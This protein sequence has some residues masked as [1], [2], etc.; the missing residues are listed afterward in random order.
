MPTQVT[1]DS[2]HPALR[3]VPVQEAP[4][5]DVEAVFGTRGD[6]A[7]CWCQWYK[8][9]RSEWTMS[10]AELAAL[11]ERQVAEGAD[12]PG[13]IAYDGATPVGWCG[14]EPRPALPGLQRKPIV[15]DGSPDQDF[16][17]ASV[18]AV[19]CFVVP[20]AHRKRGVGNKLAEAAVAYARAR[21]ARVVEAYAVDPTTKA[22]I[23]AA[24]LFPGTVSMFERAGFREVARPSASRA[25]M[26]V[27]FDDDR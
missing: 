18:W 2:R 23:P 26:Q 5:A 3:V 15:A 12:G 20:R 19:T 27:R 7:H 24:D 10:D 11:L 21:G 16:D 17:D 13:L 9:P 6:P 8:I 1:A 14:V 4:F 25:I 22:K